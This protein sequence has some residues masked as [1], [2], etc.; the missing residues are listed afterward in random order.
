MT[1]HS[2]EV[3][4]VTID[5]SLPLLL[6]TVDTLIPTVIYLFNTPVLSLGTIHQFHMSIY[7]C[8]VMG[9]SSVA[10]LVRQ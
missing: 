9:Q 6:F 4:T 5:Q 1:R 7:I 10:S 2:F 8:T 3:C